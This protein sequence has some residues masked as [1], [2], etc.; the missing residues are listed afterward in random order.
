MTNYTTLG[1]RIRYVRLMLGKWSWVTPKNY[2]K[3]DDKNN[4]ETTAPCGF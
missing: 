4:Y 2:N 1:G 3:Y